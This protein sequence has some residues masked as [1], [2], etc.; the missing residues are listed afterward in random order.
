MTSLISKERRCIIIL[1]P[2]SVI[3]RLVLTEELNHT[4]NAI[5]EMLMHKWWTQ[6]IPLRRFSSFSEPN[7]Y[8]FNY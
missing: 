2:I 4:E 8:N 6:L 3:H 1:E 5:Y 7:A